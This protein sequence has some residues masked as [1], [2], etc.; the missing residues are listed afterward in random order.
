[1]AAVGLATLTASTWA[2]RPAAPP[3]GTR[4]QGHIVRVAGPNQFVVRTADKREVIPHANPKTKFLLHERPARFLDLRERDEIVAQF[5][6]AEGQNLVSSVT[7]NP[8]DVPDAEVVEGTIVRV[9]EPENQLIVRTA[10][11]KE[12][13]L[14]ADTRTRFTINDRH[15]RIVD[16]RP[17][18]A[19]R[20]HFTAKGQRHFAHSVTAMPK[21]R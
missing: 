4:I 3:R 16:F 21:R 14:T 15:A 6:E 20:A 12:V 11:G 1:V 9:I 18:T 8:A 19:V 7:I 13:I 10:A 5:D 2:Q 17:G